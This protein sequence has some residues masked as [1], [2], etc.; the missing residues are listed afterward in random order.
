MTAKKQ[1]KLRLNIRRK[2]MGKYTPIT[3]LLGLA[4]LGYIRSPLN[5]AKGNDFMTNQ[6]ATPGQVEFI[7]ALPDGNSPEGIALDRKG[8]IYVGNRRTEGEARIPEIY[9]I[10]PG[11]EVSLLAKLPATTVTQ[12]ES[13]LGL[14][15]DPQGTVYAALHS[16]DISQGVWKITS[17][18]K[19]S[20]L[21]GSGDINFPNALIFD[22]RGNLYVTDSFSGAIWR[23]DREGNWTMWVQHELL[24]PDP[25]QPLGM[26]LPG[27]NGIAFYPPNQLYIAN[28][29]RGLIA[30]TTIQPDGSAGQVFTVAQNPALLTVDGIT[31]D[32]RGELHAVIPGYAILQTWPLVK[33]NPVSGEVIPSIL[34][35]ADNEKFDFPLSI[36][37]G[38]GARDNKSV[39]ITNGNLPLL[40]G[41]PGAGVI[42]VEV[43]V[44]GFQGN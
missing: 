1:I 2:I 22:P 5:L 8:N 32:T 23:M 37:F 29:D 13:L 4:I 30:G 43:G 19:A 44:V 18:G 7:L 10:S 20:L 9:Q 40:E 36:A 14:V 21:P 3:I 25:A 17:D 28:T 11:G 6:P 42:Q 27:A 24:T 35:E 41:G 31:V 16:R 38:T 39:F 26:P 15:T 34:D 33:V 12:A